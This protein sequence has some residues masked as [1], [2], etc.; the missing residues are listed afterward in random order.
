MRLRNLTAAKTTLAIFLMSSFTHPAFGAATDT[1][2]SLLSEG[3]L[4]ETKHEHQRAIQTFDRAANFAER[5]KLPSKCLELAVC[6]QAAVEVQANKIA[7]ANAHCDKL[8]GLVAREKA[9]NTL[10]PDLEVW[11]LNL[12]NA[13]QANLNSPTREQC[14]QKLCLINKVLYGENHKDYKTARAALAEYYE[15]TQPLKAAKI[16]ESANR[17]ALGQDQTHSDPMVQGYTLN[18]LAMNCRMI[19]DLEKAKDANLQLL[20]LAKTSPQVADGTV[21]YYASL[22]TIE[23]AQGKEAESKSYFDRARQEG[24]RIR[25]NKKKEA[26][27]TGSLKVLADKVKLDKNPKYPNLLSNELAALLTIQQSISADPRTQYGIIRLLGEAEYVENKLDDSEKCFKRAI[28]IARLPA[29]MVSNDVPELYTQMATHAAI[30]RQIERSNELF[31]KALA[32]E[33]DKKGFG[34]TRTLVYWGGTANNRGDFSLAREKLLIAMKQAYE[35]S[36]EKRGTLLLDAAWGVIPALKH[37]GQTE[38]LNEIQKVVVAEQ[39]QQRRLNTG[40]GPN[41]FHML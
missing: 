29:S 4:C 37:F 26:L 19:G 41:F 21:T 22:G 15:R 40:L 7:Q 10:D 9:S 35:L 31:N 11:I 20:K 39:H 2:K 18:Q 5:N 8:M 28:E 23:L 16:Q 6:R 34:A 12:A 17:E 3:D 27:A 13:Y 24:S 25:G 32:A 33:T 36:A 30:H 14:L 38:H 1:W